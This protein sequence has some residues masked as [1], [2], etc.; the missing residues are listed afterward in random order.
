M[1]DRKLLDRP[2]LLVAGVAAGVPLS[3]L[4]LRS[5]VLAAF[6]ALTGELAPA[7]GVLPLLVLPV[8]LQIWA[9]VRRLHRGTPGWRWAVPVLALQFLLTAP[10]AVMVGRD[11]SLALI[12]ACTVLVTLPKPWSLPAF[13]A[14][15]TV[16]VVVQWS[17]IVPAAA[18]FALLLH[19]TLAG[20]VGYAVMRMAEMTTELRRTQAHLAELAVARERSRIS[21]DL[22]DTLG[23][24]LTAIGL[25]VELAARVTGSDQARALGELRGAQQLT[26]HAARNVRRVARGELRPVFAD[27][28]AT[29]TALL[30]AGGVACRIAIDAEPDDHIGQVAGWALREGVTNVLNHSAARKCSLSTEICGGRFRLTVENDGVRDRRGTAGTGLAGITHRVAELGG[31]VNFGHDAAKNFRLVVEIPIEDDDDPARGG[32]G[33]ASAARSTGGPAVAG[34][35]P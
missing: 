15:V 22:H 19:K 9:S 21:R 6:P 31:Q 16:D 13:G 14:I 24:E 17:G 34:R 35:R 20:L 11:S 32:R 12:F 4:A 10:V 5:W 26:E 27:E 25:R 3:L 23:Q 18:L 33:H 30:E 29:G 8:A 7:P 2:T 1:I 28:L